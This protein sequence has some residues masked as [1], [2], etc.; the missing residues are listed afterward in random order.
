MHAWG[1]SRALRPLPHAVHEE[2]EQGAGM[3]LASGKVMW[4]H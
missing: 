1:V 2:L 4:V 3:L